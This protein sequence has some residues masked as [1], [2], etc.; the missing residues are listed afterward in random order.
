MVSQPFPS[1][2]TTSEMQAIEAAMFAAGL[3]IAAL[4]E[5]VGQRLSDRLCCLYPVT[6]HP[7]VG[8]LAGPGHN[9]GDAL[10]VA[11]ELWHRGY[12]VTVW[13]PFSRLKPLT[14][15]HAKYARFLGIPFTSEVAELATANLI[16]DGVFGFGLERSVSHELGAAFAQVNQWCVP[17]LSID[18]PSGLC[19]DRGAVLGTAIQATRTLCLGLWKRGLLMDEA[20]PWVGEAE[21]LTFDIPATIIDNVLGTTPRRYCLDSQC[22]QL[23]PLARSPIT[24]KYRQGQLLL[25]GGSARFG[26]SIL[27]SALAAR[28]TGVGMLVV[29]VPNS[30]KPLVLARVPDAIV[31]GCPETNTGAIAHLPADLDLQRVQAIA[32][33][34]GLT[35]A[36]TTVIEQVL[37]AGIPTVLD[38]DGLNIL[39]ALSPWPLAAPLV[40]T[41]H[42]GEF[43]RLFPDLSAEGDRL[44]QVQAAAAHSNCLV[45]L[46]GARTAIAT[47]AGNLWINPAST[48][49][50]AR[51]GSG[52]VLTGLI[53]GLLAQ[54]ELLHSTL[55][56]V[57]WH[58]QAGLAAAKQWTTLGVYPERLVD[59]LLP[60][61]SAK[62]PDFLSHQRGSEF[63][64]K[65][66]E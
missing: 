16:V 34:P 8:V 54:Q 5:K 12:T 10:V 49:A 6:T 27:L 45:V 15:D 20:L 38:A 23:L 50:L 1:I 42:L 13:Q 17:R 39:A 56:G 66:R 40:L 18:V 61:L 44:E 31:V 30:L 47:P 59:V 2:V 58:A 19:S 57:W 11:R 7:K 65:C 9:G 3:P 53:G 4:M 43:R 62:K 37:A 41:P 33:G 25:I 22:W 46:K 28:C 32:C 48:P 36:A 60:T 52:D 64:H 21:L 14:A 24:H 51:G 35:T 63:P 26:G 29:A 55:G